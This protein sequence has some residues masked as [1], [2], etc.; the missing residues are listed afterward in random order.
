MSKACATALEIIEAANEYGF[1]IHV[2]GSILTISRNIPVGDLDAFTECD[3][4]Y[5]SVLDKLPQTESG[6]VWGTDGGGMGGLTA[7]NTGR[8]VMNKSGGAKRVLAALAKM[9]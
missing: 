7:L 5:G 6:S 9:V 1:T 3:G 4:T 8:F 2:R